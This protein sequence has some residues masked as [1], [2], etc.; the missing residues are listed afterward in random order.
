MKN[1][2]KIAMMLMV[3]LPSLLAA[4]DKPNIILITIDDLRPELGIYGNKLIQTPQIDALSE[5]ATTFNNAFCQVPVCGASRASMHTGVR[6]TPKRFTS[7][8]TEIDH[9]LPNAV[10]IGQHFKENGYYTFSIG[11]VIHGKKD[12]VE[13]T[14]TEY[15]PAESMFEYHNKALVEEA[16]NPVAPYKRPQPYEVVMD[17]KDTDFLDGRS[18]KIAKER[19]AELKKKDQPFFMAVGIAR[20]HLPFVA[21][22]RF[23]DLY[24]EDDIPMAD[25]PYKPE[26]MPEVAKTTYG[27][28]RAYNSV[29]KKGDVPSDL[30]KKLKHGYYASVSFSDYLVGDLIAELKKQGLYENS[31]IVLWGDH[32]W[33]LGEH[34]FWAK[35]TNFDI[36]LRVPLIIK[37]QEGKNMT[38]AKADGFAEI[39]DIFPTL[40][41]LAGLEGPSQLQGQSLVPVLKDHNFSTKEYALSRWK[42]GDS[43]RTKG[44][45][46]TAF[47]NKKGVLIAEMMYDLSKDPEE[48]KNIV[49]DA[50]YK[51]EVEKH[52][53]LLDKALKEYS[54]I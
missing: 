48:N 16:K 2:V 23:W 20:P 28:L 46:Y 4:Q 35:H 49:K 43:I 26:N 8:G 37:P 52:R 19:L 6:P 38:A 24:N 53:K 7:A 30:A 21:P 54:L 34:S 45:R 1:L 33:Q 50:T 42:Q 13:R 9:D 10:T 36:A 31:I 11:K 18:V 15:H 44:Y 22:K 41:D 27:E 12:A 32:G 51:V 5:H 47:K 39:V 29:P 40:C 25:N 14:W 17:S 3:C